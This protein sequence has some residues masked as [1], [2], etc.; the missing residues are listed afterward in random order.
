MSSSTYYMH[1]LIEI[2]LQAA[3]WFFYAFECWRNLRLKTTYLTNKEIQQ[4]SSRKILE[5]EYDR[6]H[7]NNLHHNTF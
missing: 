3:I 6:A 7:E 1:N 5:L 4:Q 2:I